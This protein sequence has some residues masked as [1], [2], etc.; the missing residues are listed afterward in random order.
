MIVPPSITD[1]RHTPIRSPNAVEQDRA[2]SIKS[3][4]KESANSEAKDKDRT[5]L[6]SLGS[7]LS[8]AALLVKARYG[9]QSKQQLKT[10]Y[11]ETI[12]RLDGRQYN[13]HKATHNLEVPDSKDPQRLERAKQATYYVNNLGKNPFSGMPPEQ[14]ELIIFDDSGNFTTNERRAAM[15]ES[16]RQEQAWRVEVV[17]A[18]QLEQAQTGKQTNFYQ[19]VLDHYRSLPSIEKSTYPEGYEDKLQGWINDEKNIDTSP[20]KD[21]RA[22]HR[23]LSPDIALS[24]LKRED[25]AFRT[26]HVFEK[27]GTP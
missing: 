22:R 11:S 27:T 15:Y 18:A 17:A 20:R 5:T 4:E 8:N 6:T 24:I 13:E 16:N 9:S 12:N 23:R 1:A 25:R 7:Q 14:L 21:E 19:A 2:G 26:A 10:L 3:I